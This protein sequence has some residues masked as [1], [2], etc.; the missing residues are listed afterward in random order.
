[1]FDV[2]S[3]AVLHPI[4]YSGLRRVTSLRFREKVEIEPNVWTFVFEPNTPLTW[5][6]GQH[7]IFTLPKQNVIGK[8]WRPFSVA[9]SPYEGL[10]RIATN[11]PPTPS[12][13]KQKLMALRSGDEIRMIGPF[14]EFHLNKKPETIV[15]I[16]GGIGITPF[17]ALAY[18]IA[19]GHTAPNT[20]LHL[21]Y[22]ARNHH[23]FG[24]ELEQWQARSDKLT[25][26]YIHTPE[27]VSAALHE[28]STLYP[29]STRYF[30]SGAPQMITALIKNI[31][32]LGIK[33][34]VND[35]FKGY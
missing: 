1:M 25:V 17:R 31:R 9:S 22:S 32:A 30:I 5:K 11:L 21:I 12:D 13:F 15:G 10:I 6:S 20:K 29:R 28:T 19:H 23:P 26:S 27:E 16:A 14:G 33:T 3:R 24:T 35:P 8:S 34:I 7:A 4:D 18:D 2:F